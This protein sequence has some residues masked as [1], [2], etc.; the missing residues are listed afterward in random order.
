MRLPLLAFS[1][2]LAFLVFPHRI[3]GDPT[4]NASKW[5]AVKRWN[6]WTK[7]TQHDSSN[8]TSDC[9]GTTRGE[10][11]EETITTGT[12]EFHEHLYEEGPEG[13]DVIN[14][15]SDHCKASGSKN[16]NEESVDCEGKRI[17]TTI[18]GSGPDPGDTHESMRID[19][20][21][22]TYRLGAHTGSD[23]TLYR[24]VVTPSGTDDDEFQNGHG[25]DISIDDVP[26]P[27]GATTVLSGTRTFDNVTD[28]GTLQRTIVEWR[29]TPA[30]REELEV[31]VDPDQYEKW[32]PEGGEDEDTSGNHIGI[33][34][35]L[36]AKD[37][38]V[39][40]QKAVRFIFEL[41]DTSRIPGVCGNRPQAADTDYDMRF[42]KEANPRLQ[43]SGTWRQTAETEVGEYTEATATVSSYDYGGTCQIRVRAI[44]SD[45]SEV[46]GHLKGDKSQTDVRLPKRS[47]ESK[48]ADAW[49]KREGVQS[50]EDSDDSE[51]IPKLDGHD[52]DGLT[53]FEEYR[54]FRE[55]GEHFRANPKR[56]EL[57][58]VD[59]V[60]GRTKD[61]I[62]LM[63]NATGLLVYDRLLENEADEKGVV[64]TNHGGRIPRLANKY[65]VRI[66]EFS[67]KEGY[68]F[69]F[70]KP[71]QPKT[72]LLNSDLDSGPG[73][74]QR[75]WGK[76][77]I[78]DDYAST[79]AHE[80]MH[81]LNVEHHGDSDPRTSYW[82][83][84]PGDL[85]LLEIREYRMLLGKRLPTKGEVIRVM[86]ED[87]RE[88]GP[89]SRSIVL[90][91][92]FY[93][94]TKHGEHSGN[95][96]CMMRYKCA[97]A[98][99]SPTDPSVRYLVTGEMTGIGFCRDVK[100]TGVNDP[101]RKPRPR[102]GSASK[103]KCFEQPCVNDAA[104]H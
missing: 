87:G 34:A 100:G 25:H 35:T 2:I 15:F 83:A 52:G 99:R 91:G 56:K 96:D 98:Y 12:L 59:S 5:T 49:K 18:R 33:F 78:T 90:P 80:I 71:G 39:P 9:G 37:G 61:G 103:G 54:G 65:A 28:A 76:R 92:E 4:P 88:V 10:W 84:E 89:R 75:S 95:E 6:L 17:V 74:W 7:A 31:I 19:Q 85:G 70:G 57:F 36:Q 24:H 38:S 53:L 68:C 27:K 102:Y 77:I 46:V 86:T 64:N 62:A 1:C 42:D 93:V 51:E 47:A 73:G 22:G 11:H 14:W 50:L 30:D 23:Y 41:V 58:I 29:L 66:E 45:G 8:Y 63:R 97:D 26:L 60:G 43:I 13:I 40:Q 104:A 48:I 55:N 72:V 67:D 79:V 81:C 32:I 82:V 69:G 44:M 21:K 101:G 3:A 16:L 94:A 20:K